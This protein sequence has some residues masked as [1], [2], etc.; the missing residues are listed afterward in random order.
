MKIRIRSYK[1]TEDF[2]LV[3]DFLIRHYQPGNRDGNWF[4]PTWEYMHSHPY[5]DETALDKIGIWETS[6]EI[7]GVAHYES[8]L[9]E[10]FFETHPD[11]VCLKPEML[12]YAER[13]LFGTDEDGK[14]YVKVFVNDFDL[15]F[16]EL[17]QSQGYQRIADYDR[18]ISQYIIPEPFPNINLPD[19]FR[20][21]SLQEDNNL[22]KIHRVLWRGFGHE[23]EPSDDGIEDRRKMQDVPNFRKD[24]NVVIEGPDG[25]FVSYCGMWFDQTNRIAYVEPVATDPDYRCLGLG[26]VAVLEGIRRCGENGAMEA[27]VGSDQDF[28]MAIGFTKVFT[29]QCWKKS[30]Q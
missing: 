1:K 2:Q 18:P 25:N 13:Q 11:Y 30:V 20:V 6:K 23:G 5:L 26:K 4:Q 29:S 21:K 24:L 28:Y 7:V 9:G 14:R 10:V 12:D 27:F 15:E 8:K 3:G 22:H 16:E 17:V 19:G